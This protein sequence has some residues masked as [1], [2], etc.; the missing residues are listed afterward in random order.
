MAREISVIQQQILDSIAADTTVGPLLTSTSKRAV[1]RNFAFIV[2]AAIGILEQL[3]DVFTGN[4]EATAAAA[5][6][7]SYNWLQAQ[8]FKFQYSS[9]IPQVVQFINFAPSY[10][11]VDATLQI[12]TRC[13]VTTSLSNTVLI[14]VAKGAVPGPLAAGE[15]TALSAY[16]NPPFGLGVAGINYII[17]SK[18][19]DKLYVQADI[20]YQGTF[21]SVIQLNVI[22]AINAYLA[23]LPFNGQMKVVDLEQAIRKVEGVNDVLLKNV[24]ARPD[25]VAFGSG[26]YLVQA[27]N[28]MSRLWNTDSGYMVS[29]TTAANT[30]ADTLNFIAE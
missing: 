20:F 8:I 3:I 25:I 2:A 27:N 28:V 16:V 13:S 26:T 23:S 11:V 29:E 12:I 5:A 10:P 15:V 7:A 4:V 14:K 6:P 24:V 22:N 18:D 9:T 21:S 17:S 30:L 19:S 1:F